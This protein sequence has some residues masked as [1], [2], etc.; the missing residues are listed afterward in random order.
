CSTASNQSKRSGMQLIMSIYYDKTETAAAGKPR[1]MPTA[2]RGHADS[3]RAWPLRA[4]AMAHKRRGGPRSRKQ[5][6]HGIVLVAVI[7]MIAVSLALFGLWAGAIAR[8]RYRLD[9]P[10][11]RQ[12]AESLAAAGL[13][14]A[15]ARR[16]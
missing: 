16:A 15:V 4:V 1:A 8:E 6:R 7:V 3:M 11:F 14:R 9:L 5:R 2:Q 10:Q 12:Q 13:E